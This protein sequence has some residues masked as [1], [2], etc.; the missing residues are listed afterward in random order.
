MGDRLQRDKRRGALND[1]QVEDVVLVRPLS[2]S[3]VFPRAG[4]F[5]SI[6]REQGPRFR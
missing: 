1:R 5:A 6:R 2:H 4:S 3:V